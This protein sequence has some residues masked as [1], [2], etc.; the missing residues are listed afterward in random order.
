MGISAISENN[1]IRTDMKV[2]ID[3]KSGFCFG[4]VNAIKSAE[5]E[6][7]KE[8]TLYCLGDIVHN[9]LEVERLKSMGL[10][11]INRQDLD[12]LQG[13]K[14]LLRAHGEPP[15]TYELA[16]KNNIRIIDTTC[17]VVLKLQQKIKS[18]Y[19][20]ARSRTQLVIYGK[21]GHAEVNGL[22][23]QTE[24]TA[25]VIETAEDLEKLDYSRNIILFAQT[26]KSLKGFRKLVELIE[27]RMTL[28]G[29]FIYHDTIC[30]QVSNRLQDI[31]KFVEAHDYIYFVAGLKS[32]N[33]KILYEECLKANHNCIFI[34][35]PEEIID[36]LPDSVK[37]VGVC[38]ATSTPK[39]L[40]EQV[41]T[42]IKQINNIEEKSKI[43]MKFTDICCEIFEQA[44]ADYHTTNDPDSQIEIPYPYKSIEY[45]LYQKNMIDVVQWHLEDL[46]RDPNIDPQKALELKR[47]IDRSN[48]ERTDLVEV[49][50]NYFLDM[51]KS[52]TVLPDAVI[53][54]ESPAWAIDRLSI[55]IIKIFHM[56]EETIRTDATPEHRQICIDKLTILLEQ[57]NDLCK[58]IEQLFEDIRLGKKYM[59]VYKQMKMY[60]DPTLNPVLYNG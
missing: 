34:S 15:I 60:N 22:V 43:N 4:V 42:R 32:S 44:T 19:T 59:K 53:N 31:K 30:R 56:R 29:R 21:K 47:R 27:S 1:P 7:A 5:L 20:G 24:G 23:G 18:Y 41:A 39:W 28:M 17:P 51:Y 55:L 48:Q 13:K 35:R 8:E 3:K 36:P 40:M 2:E 6:L 25:I 50:D 9:S 12:N 57:K 37:T 58:A 45:N 46:I 11:T 26:T 52:T 54:T 14:V 16:R 49:I 10:I 33:G 38:G